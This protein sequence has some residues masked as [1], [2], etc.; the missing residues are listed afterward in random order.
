MIC[1][2]IWP[3]ICIQGIAWLLPSLERMS[4]SL[5]SMEPTGD[6]YLKLVYYFTFKFSYSWLYRKRLVL[7]ECY[8]LSNKPWKRFFKVYISPSS[9]TVCDVSHCYWLK[10][11]VL[12]RCITKMP[13]L[14]ELDIQD[15]RMSLKKM[16]KVF[17]ACQKIAKLSLTLK[18][19]N[20]DEFKKGIIEK[21]SLKW[22][23]KGFK[24]ITHLQC[25]ERHFYFR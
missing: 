21:S 3:N 10:A 9:I 6:E 7:S 4:A 17:E 1:S 13:N 20:L 2:S 23:K 18:E 19:A 25:W 16:P 11:K 12:L 24:K 14:E 8:Y 22:M 15:T 5:F